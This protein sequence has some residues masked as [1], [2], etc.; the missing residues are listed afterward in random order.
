MTES[1]QV[2]SINGDIT[3]T[4]VVKS[5]HGVQVFRGYGDGG[6]K[7]IIKKAICN[8]SNV[9]KGADSLTVSVSVFDGCWAGDFGGTERKKKTDAGVKT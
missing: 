3:E 5:T 2:Y 7:R 8:E 1:G 9:E 4:A 6:L